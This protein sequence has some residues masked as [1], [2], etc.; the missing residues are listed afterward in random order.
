VEETNRY[1]H[2]Y[3]ATPHD[4]TGNVVVF[5]YYYSDGSQPKRQTE[6][7][8][9]KTRTVLYS[10]LRKRMK[11]D[12]FFHI[13]RFLYFSDKRNERDQTDEN[14][15]SLWKMRT[16]LISSIMHMLNTTLQPYIRLSMKSLFCSK[17][18]SFPNSI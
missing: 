3:L 15:D 17:V 6:R 2:Q 4:Y 14:Y 1:Y 13:L 5:I 12:T 11:E 10:L 8:L 7:Q 18:T 16:T 9:V